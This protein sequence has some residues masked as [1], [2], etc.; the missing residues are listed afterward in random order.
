M[1]VFVILASL[2]I[3]SCHSTTQPLASGDGPAVMP[4]NGSSFDYQYVGTDTSGNAINLHETV[5]IADTL[6][7]FSAVRTSDTSHGIQT[8][9]SVIYT[10]LA[11]GDLQ[12]N[13]GCEDYIYPIQSQHTYLVSGDSLLTPSKTNGVYYEAN[14]RIELSYL[15]AETLNAAGETFNCSKIQRHTTITASDVSL[16]IPTIDET[17]IFWYSSKFGYFVKEQNTISP[18]V[19]PG[20]YT[21]ILIAHR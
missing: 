3:M 20:N 15:G 6:N 10:I 1:R 21:R 11:N 17:T 19:P 5:T 8:H 13:C 12:N 4:P 18:N 14:A 7:G 9:D 2:A 16:K